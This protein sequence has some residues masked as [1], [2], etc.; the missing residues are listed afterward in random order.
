MRLLFKFFFPCALLLFGSWQSTGLAYAQQAADEAALIKGLLHGYLLAADGHYQ[1][2]APII[3]DIGIAQK[4]GDIMASAVKIALQAGDAKLAQKYADAWVTFSGSIRAR[5][6]QAELLLYN[7][8]WPQAEQHLAALM[9]EKAQDSSDLLRQLS[10]IANQQQAV[11]IA[12]RLFPGDADGRYHFALLAFY[13]QAYPP[14]LAAAKEA[15]AADPARLD[16]LFLAARLA[17]RVEGDSAP[18]ALLQDYVKNQCAAAIRHCRLDA[19]LW[20]FSGYLRD[21]P[22]WREA[23]SAPQATP[24]EWAIAAGNWY[25]QWDMPDEAEKA[26]QRGGDRFMAQRGLAQLAQTRGDLAQALAIMKKA[27]VADRSEF[28]I[29]E[30]MITYLLMDSDE[31]AEALERITQA[32]KT[33]ADDFDLMYIHSLVLEKNKDINAAIAILKRITELFPD[34]PDGWNALGYV[35]ADNHVRLTEAKTYIER[36]LQQKSNDPNIIDSLGWVYYRLGDLSSAR[37]QLERAAAL[38]DSV[39]IHTHYAEVLWELGHM[40]KA[41]EIWA[42]ARLKEPDNKVLQETLARYQIF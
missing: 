34:N 19:V 21:Q 3:G 13:K 39:E 8:Q 28:I 12:Q 1:E 24:E 6:T 10:I 31:L 22:E 14:A 27:D 40:E 25:L 16:A 41:K 35:M 26:Y 23:L 30:R 5:Q 4:D 36:A 17:Q 42:Q 20:A 2:A 11:D 37:T 7:K 29:R 18:L 33:A 15:L 9:A 32:Q 38:S